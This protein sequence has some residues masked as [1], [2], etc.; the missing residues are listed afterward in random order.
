MVSGQSFHD[1]DESPSI[2]E[3]RCTHGLKKK[4]VKGNCHQGLLSE[5]MGLHEYIMAWLCYPGIWLIAR[6]GHIGKGSGV[7]DNEKGGHLLTKGSLAQNSNQTQQ[8]EPA[9]VLTI[10]LVLI[11]RSSP[12]TK[13]ICPPELIA[14]RGLQVAVL[15]RWNMSDISILDRMNGIENCTAFNRD[16]LATLAGYSCGILVVPCT[17]RDAEEYAMEHQI[18]SASYRYAFS[19]YYLGELDWIMAKLLPTTSFVHGDIC[20]PMNMLHL[21]NQIK[22]SYAGLELNLFDRHVRSKEYPSIKLDWTQQGLS[23]LRG[24]S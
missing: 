6:S 24:S 18:C 3:Y 10:A 4:P 21:A 15:W 19:R 11:Q 22:N 14:N 17:Q 7:Q 16:C 20:N 8:N 2:S 1:K 5:K 9:R 12:E 13:W 23:G